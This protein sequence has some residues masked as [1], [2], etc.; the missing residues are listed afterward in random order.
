MTDKIIIKKNI[1]LLNENKRLKNN[2]NDLKQF[3]KDKYG[4]TLNSNMFDALD[5]MH[6]LE[7]RK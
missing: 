3:I 6:K 7:N 4:E 1:E 5:Y 2:W